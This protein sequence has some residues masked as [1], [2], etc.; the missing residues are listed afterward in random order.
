MNAGAALPVPVFAGVLCAGAAAWGLAGGDRVSRRARVLLAGG[1]PVVP[2]GPVRWERLVVGVRVRAAGRREWGCLGVGLVVALLGGSVIP[3]VLG[4]AAVPLVRRWLRAR[5]RER[6]RAARAAEVVALCGAAVGELRAGAQPGQALT[7]AIR[8]T[9]SG[10]GGPGAAE[11]GVLAAAAFGGD[12]PG[13]L[14]LAAR[15]PGAEGLAGMAAC[16]RVSVDGGAGLAAGLDRLEGALRAER[17]RRES[18]RA[19]LAGARST[20]VVL[21]LLPLVGLLIGTGLGA[22]PLRVLLHT[23][24]GWGCLGAGGVLEA[25]GLLWCRRIV[26]AGEW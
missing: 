14:R 26:G 24:V 2:G 20:A 21:A 8:R 16:W 3:V 1:G 10:P 4:A 7:A 18:L 9:A 25:L 17:D 11:A 5:E 6:A 15:E 23:P 13:A 22:D 12:V 19:Q